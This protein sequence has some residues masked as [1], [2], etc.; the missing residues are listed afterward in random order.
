[1]E[2]ST[3]VIIV[4]A[5][6]IG[7]ACGIEAS[8]RGI[9]ADI[10]DKGCLTNSIFRYPP[11]L[12]FFSSPHLLELGS[13]PFIT[14][15]PK[16]TRAEVLAYYRRLTE[17]FELK[18]QLFERVEEIRTDGDTG[19]LIRTAKGRAV[20]AKYV[21]LAVGFYD[22]PNLLGVPGEELPKVSHYYMEPHPFYRQKVAVIGAQ[23]SAAEA[24][25]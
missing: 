8:C 16:P 3:N 18:V 25:L 14:G 9:A 12:V 19:Y 13:V 20:K 2:T 1:M 6:P 17:F 11:Q 5:G 22:H 7:I 10:F 24:A 23:N 15:G 4:G 21:V